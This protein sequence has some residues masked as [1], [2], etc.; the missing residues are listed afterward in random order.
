MSFGWSAGDIVAAVNTLVKVRKAL[1]QSGGAAAEYQEAVTFLTAL[2]KTL[3]GLQVVLKNNPGLEWEA[4]LLEQANTLTSSVEDFK[5][6]IAK[7][8]LSLGADT[9]RRKARRI[10]REVQFALSDR[11]KEL[12][13]AITQPQLVLD[14][15]INLQ[16]L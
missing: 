7:Y 14:V 9:E 4:G 12:R 1:K 3:S 15:F 10:A 8:D 6:K 13:I 2:G 11:V 16:T 5:K